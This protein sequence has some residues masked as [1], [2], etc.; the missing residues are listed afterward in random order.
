MSDGGEGYGKPYIREGVEF[1]GG[2]LL[3]YA[4]W[5]GRLHLDKVTFVQ[6]L[7]ENEL[8]TMWMSRERDSQAEG[9]VVQRP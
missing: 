5:L 8:K 6:R 3:L 2:C 1:T 7:E 4:E 9:A